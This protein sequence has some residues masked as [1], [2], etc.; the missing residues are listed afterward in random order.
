MKEWHDTFIAMA[1]LC[2]VQDAP[3]DITGLIGNAAG[4][5]AVGT[6]GHRK[7]LQR[8][9]LMKHVECMLK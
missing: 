3:M 7:Y 2:S 1:G 8:V 4:A 5:A 6:V 9:P